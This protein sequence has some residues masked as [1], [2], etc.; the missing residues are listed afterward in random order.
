MFDLVAGTLVSTM[1]SF[2]WAGVP[3]SLTG[4]GRGVDRRTCPWP[5]G[6]VLAR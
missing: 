6:T 4:Q 3:G 1:V 2:Q 5:L